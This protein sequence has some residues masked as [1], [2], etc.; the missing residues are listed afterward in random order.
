MAPKTEITFFY[1]KWS[2]NDKCTCHAR[3]FKSFTF[4]T[5]DSTVCLFHHTWMQHNWTPTHTSFYTAVTRRTQVS[6]CGSR[7]QRLTIST[8]GLCVTER[9]NSHP[10]G[11]PPPTHT[12]DELRRQP[13]KHNKAL[14]SWLTWQQ[15]RN[16]CR[17]VTG[18]TR[19]EWRNSVCW[20]ACAAW[21]FGSAL[22]LYR[23]DKTGVVSV[24][25]MSHKVKRKLHSSEERRIKEKS[26]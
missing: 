12:Q 22:R 13:I 2:R 15:S 5:T 8:A 1:F 7:G 24:G 18:H 26:E 6:Y 14:T 17:A 3:F 23:R 11:N 9:S 10:H 19:G 4:D 21:E 16:S 20:H 25:E